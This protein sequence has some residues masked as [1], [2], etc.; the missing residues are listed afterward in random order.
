MD[1][2]RF[3]IKVGFG[4]EESGAQKPIW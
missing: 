3:C 1:L 2:G 4:T